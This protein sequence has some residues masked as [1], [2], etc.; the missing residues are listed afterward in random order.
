[1][2]SHDR[3]ERTTRSPKKKGA[4]TVVLALLSFWPLLARGIREHSDLKP[5][6]TRLEAESQRWSNLCFNM[7][8]WFSAHTKLIVGCD[9]GCP[10]RLAQRWFQDLSEWNRCETMRD[11][12][13]ANP[14][15]DTELVMMVIVHSV[16]VKV[17]KDRNCCLNRTNWN[18]SLSAYSK[19]LNTFR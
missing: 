9:V 12:G 15:F 14:T 19:V 6:H 2:S 17:Q 11:H 10:C 4:Q 8:D 5:L 13:H 16:R 3:K 7:S 18:H 1:M